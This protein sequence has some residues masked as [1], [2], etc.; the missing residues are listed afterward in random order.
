MSV[1]RSANRPAASLLPL[2]QALSLALL[3]ALP[4]VWS[5]KV[6]TASPARYDHVLVHRGDSLWSLVSK[7]ASRADDV[8]EAVY[9]AAAIN[10]M[11]ATDRLQPGSVVLLPHP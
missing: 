4:T 8:A 5:A 3:F 9:Q 10:H 7:H 11:H 2:I 6:F 1:Y